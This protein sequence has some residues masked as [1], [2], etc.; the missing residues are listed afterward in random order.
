[1]DEGRGSMGDIA[2][3]SVGKFIAA[4]CKE[5]HFVADPF[6]DEAYAFTGRTKFCSIS[7]MQQNHYPI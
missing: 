4:S 7:R 2:R 6:M 5:I 1:M 3:D